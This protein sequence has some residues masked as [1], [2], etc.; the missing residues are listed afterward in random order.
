MRSL[1]VSEDDQVVWEAGDKDEEAGFC[2]PPVGWQELV[3]AGFRLIRRFVVTQASGKKR[4]IDDALAG[5]Q[6]EFSSDAN[7]L[8]FCSAIQPCLHAQVFAAELARCGVSCN[9]WPDDLVSAGEDLPNAYRKIPTRPDH[10]W[11]CVVAYHDCQAGGLR[12]RRYKGMLFGLPLAVLAFNRLSLFLQCVCRRLLKALV[13]LCFDDLTLQDWQSLAAETQMQVGQLFELFGF[14]FLVEK[15]QEP[16]ATGDFL[17]LMHDFSQI[18][19]GC[20]RVWVRERLV[21][22]I[23]D[24]IQEALSTDTLKPGQASKQFGCVTFLDQGVFGRVARA[25]LTAIKDRQ[26][27]SRGDARLNCELRSA[28]NT[29]QAV[30]D[31]QPQRLVRVLPKLGRR[32]VAASDAVP[33]LSLLP[34][35]NG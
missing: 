17:G 27:A 35:K 5:R 19:Q 11:A 26:Y 9:A 4:V 22:N 31:M 7:K 24:I 32:V 34:G 2:H 12:F 18:Q 13:S 28:F 8:Q 3:A 1:R 16:A 29:I 15:R 20:V 10:S 6:S 23:E 30:L 14:P 33:F 25:G 21:Q